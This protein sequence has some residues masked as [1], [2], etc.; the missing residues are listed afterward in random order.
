MNTSNT[1]FNI[2]LSIEHRSNHILFYKIK[3]PTSN[4]L[5]IWSNL[6]PGKRKHY[7]K[8]YLNLLKKKGKNKK[9]NW[10]LKKK[11]SF[12]IFKKNL[13]L[14]KNRPVF[15]QELKPKL[16]QFKEMYLKGY[17]PQEEKILVFKTK[18][19]N[20]S[21]KSELLKVNNNQ[22]Q[23][24]F[25]RFRK[26]KLPKYKLVKR[27][28]KPKALK[29]SLRTK[30]LKDLLLEKK[31][32]P[33]TLL[34]SALKGKANKGK[35]DVLPSLKSKSKLTTAKA[36]FAKSAKAV[37]FAKVALIKFAKEAKLK[38][39]STKKTKQKPLFPSLIKVKD[40]PLCL[41][42]VKEKKTIPLP[43]AKAKEKKA[44][45]VAEKVVKKVT[46]NQKKT[47]KTGERKTKPLQPLSIKV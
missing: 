30:S 28:G 27:P 36:K 45:L 25:F 26:T 13:Y 39:K 29:S 23:I 1:K 3:I 32:K 40:K 20:L 5:S 37:K 6:I 11:K 12:S 46:K 8:L 10:I 35:L 21:I 34:S 4:L 41:L 44:V 42:S 33:F 43:S 7:S 14:D 38:L 22:A 19:Q 24:N 17:T 15:K 31:F 47:A 9:S 18:K 2:S 16:R